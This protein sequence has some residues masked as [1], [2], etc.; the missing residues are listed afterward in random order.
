MPSLPMPKSPDWR[1][2]LEVGMNF[3]EPRRAQVRRLV[4][5]LVAQGQ[6]AR[7]QA[8]ATVEEILELGQHRAEALRAAVRAEVAKQVRALGVATQDDLVALER[9]L[10]RKVSTAA[11]KRPQPV[12]KKLAA[13]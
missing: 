9:R 7:D 4:N 11:K 1:Q 2:I 5:D 6:V 3:A 12:A 10:T 13:S 8:S